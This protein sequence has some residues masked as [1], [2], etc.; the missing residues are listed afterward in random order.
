MLCCHELRHVLQ[1]HVKF[2]GESTQTATEEMESVNDQRK[3]HRENEQ[4]QL[5]ENTSAKRAKTL[6]KMNEN[7]ESANAEV[8]LKNYNS[9]HN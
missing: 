9:A 8:I 3:R 7:R 2:S 4:K 1:F 6:P 5:S